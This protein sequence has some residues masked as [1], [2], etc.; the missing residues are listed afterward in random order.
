MELVTF[1]GANGELF[2]G[3]ERRGNDTIIRDAL[4]DFRSNDLR[5]SACRETPPL[6]PVLGRWH[7]GRLHL[8]L[9]KPTINL[10]RAR[11]LSRENR[12]AQVGKERERP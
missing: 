10:D 7:P 8:K 4:K 11:T 9:N 5:Q 3:L 2:T 12:C 1:D 6:P